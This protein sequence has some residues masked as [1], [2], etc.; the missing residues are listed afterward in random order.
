AI[1][2]AISETLRLPL[3]VYTLPATRSVFHSG[4]RPQKGHTSGGYV[5]G[6]ITLPASAQPAAPTPFTGL[7]V[8]LTGHSPRLPLSV[9]AMRSAG[10]AA[11]IAAEPF[12]DE[13]A[14]DVQRVEL[15]EGHAA[16]VRL[17][18]IVAPPDWKGIA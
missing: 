13:A 9:F 3:P 14:V 18:E 12:G 11:V 1:R 7:I 6:F 15:I 5:S 10:I 4:Y 17:F 2:N 16:L 8:F